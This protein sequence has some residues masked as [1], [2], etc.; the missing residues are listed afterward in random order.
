MLFV[1]IMVKKRAALKKKK[2]TK[3]KERKNVCM[4]FVFLRAYIYIFFG[5]ESITVFNI[6]IWASANDWEE[7][8]GLS[9]EGDSY[10][11]E[12]CWSK[13]FF[14]H[15]CV[16]DWKKILLVLIVLQTKNI[17]IQSHLDFDRVFTLKTA[18]G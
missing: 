2:K 5:N 9:P 6:Y 11:F 12:S 18:S 8:I 10:R 17:Y 4:K 13:G 15:S 16:T 7:K 3:R 1:T 14:S